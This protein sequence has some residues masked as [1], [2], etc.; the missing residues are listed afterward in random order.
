[1]RYTFTF[2]IPEKRGSHENNHVDF[3]KAAAKQLDETLSYATSREGRRLMAKLKEKAGCDEWELIQECWEANDELL[4]KKSCAVLGEALTGGSTAKASSPFTKV[5]KKPVR[6]AK[7]A[8]EEKPDPIEEEE[9]PETPQDIVPPK[10]PKFPFK[11]SPDTATA[12]EEEDEDPAEEEIAEQEELLPEF[13][14]DAEETISEEGVEDIEPAPPS[15]PPSTPPSKIGSIKR[16]AKGMTGF[17][18][19]SSPFK[20]MPKFKKP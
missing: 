8:P 6:P 2:E 19:K 15:G 17:A 7:K 18:K 4:G 20:K 1:M 10:K 5:S 16:P 14:D 3:L 11:K 13:E 12:T 9:E